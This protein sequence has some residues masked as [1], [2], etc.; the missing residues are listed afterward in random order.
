MKI[1]FKKL[2]FTAL[3]S[4]GLSAPAWS[5]PAVC[6][7]INKNH[8][9]ID[10]S[11]AISCLASGVGNLQGSNTD[12]FANGT[13]WSFIEKSENSNPGSSYGLTY[14]AG[15]GDSTSITGSWS[16]SSTFWDTYGEAALGFKFGTGNTPDEWFVFDVKNG[17][18]GG[19]WTFFSTLVNGNGT[20]GLSHMNLY[21]K[22]K[23]TS[24]SEP[25]TLGLLGLGLL[26][27]SLTRRRTIR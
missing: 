2:C 8:M 24:V 15:A 21:A 4:L 22:E 9:T 12:F 23:G 25:A 10:T 27:L 3:L 13:D 5:I 26:G 19:D 11:W 20:G 16:F 1:T 6:Q 14:T 7:D 17:S 18:T